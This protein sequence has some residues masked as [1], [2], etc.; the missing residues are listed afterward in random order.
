MEITIFS[1]RRTSKD[2]KTFFQYLTTLTKKDDTTEV[3]RVCFR[4]VDAPKPESCP[5][6]IIVERDNSNI[7]TRHYTDNST[8]ELKTSRTLWV[9]AWEP[10][11]EY[12]DHS[13]DDY[14]FN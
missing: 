14:N 13:L 10:G 8:G 1:K 9:S 7:A 6:N 11:T 3:L 12:I 4:N 2:N 5:R